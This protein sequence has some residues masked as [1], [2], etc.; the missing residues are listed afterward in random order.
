MN[1]YVI[2]IRSLI[3]T[4]LGT[5]G[6]LAIASCNGSDSHTPA[7]EP[8]P[9][10]LEIVSGNDQT[11][12]TG[13]ELT[14][15]V[16]VRAH[17]SEG[18]AI[19]GMKVSFEI[20]AGGG[21]LSASSAV[22]DS[23]GLASVRWRLG[24]APVWNQMRSMANGSVVTFR[25][26]AEPG[27]P[28]AL[29][30]VH[31][32][33]PGIPS[34]DLAFQQG[35]GLF[36]GSTGA[37]LTAAAPGSGLIALDINGEEIQSPVG[38]AFGHTGELFVSDNVSQDY[39]AV[40]RITPSGICSTLSD[41]FNGQDFSLPN[42][43]AVHGSGEIYVAA[44]CNNMI[45][46]ISPLDGETHEVLHTPGP[47]GLAFNQ[48][49]SYLYFTTENPAFFC[50]GENVNGGLF[51]VAIGPDH[52][53]G[54]TE[55][56]IENVALAGDGLAFDAEGNLYIVFTGVK[57]SG[58]TSGVFV[59]TPDGRFNRFFSVN[60]C[61]LEIITNVAFGMEPFDPCSLYCYGFTGKLYS[62]AVGIRGRPLP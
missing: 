52:S 46:R 4:I 33:P 27:E 26:W 49:Y 54:Q 13:Q 19:A 7:P 55:T 22:T 5:I 38:I 44:T 35:R 61:Q 59:Y 42:D 10:F 48:D 2:T 41:G 56:L 57:G 23:S 16:V 62:A 21:H 40:K 34:E 45:Y 20:A 1:R 14:D 17:T 25:A 51:R 58:R 36:L 37:I 32:A 29:E 53:P 30:L 43:I 47:N 60:L 31:E 12:T 11:G 28:P 15:P 50:Q 9:V 24:T 3:V 6:I 18:E 8:V 39:A